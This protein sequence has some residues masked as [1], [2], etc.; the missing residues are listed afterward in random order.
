MAFVHAPIELTAKLEI[1]RKVL[2]SHLMYPD[3]TLRVHV[4]KIT[5]AQIQRG[6]DAFVFER[7]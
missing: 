1:G 2:F 6:S 5:I 7:V 3:L 4:G